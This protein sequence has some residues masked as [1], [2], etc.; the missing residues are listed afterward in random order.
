MEKWERWIIRKKQKQKNP[1]DLFEAVVPSSVIMF[2]MFYQQIMCVWGFMAAGLHEILHCSVPKL[3]PYI[4][5]TA[6]RSSPVRGIRVGMYGHT[7]GENQSARKAALIIF[8]EV[9]RR[10][11]KKLAI[12]AP[13]P[14]TVTF[15]VR[16]HIA[17][18]EHI[19]MRPQV[20]GAHS[21]TQWWDVSTF[22]ST[23]TWL[24]IFFAALYSHNT[25]E[26]NFVHFTPLHNFSYYLQIECFCQGCAFLM[27]FFFFFICN[28]IKTINE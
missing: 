2:K 8:C 19:S 20:S 11:F 14:L 25:L 5:S 22:S 15:S 24:F 3:P 18:S 28:R 7:A 21:Y 26:A 6:V 12:S 16:E 9:T 10:G 27:F 1:C 13:C 17:L 4:F 23:S